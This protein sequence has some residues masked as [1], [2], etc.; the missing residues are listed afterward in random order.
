M[1]HPPRIPSKLA[2]LNLHPHEHP[3]LAGHVQILGPMIQRRHFEADP[4]QAPGQLERL[5]GWYATVE[6]SDNMGAIQWSVGEF[7]ESHETVIESQYYAFI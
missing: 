4:L 1:S 7:N 3:L 2:T 5:I 6:T